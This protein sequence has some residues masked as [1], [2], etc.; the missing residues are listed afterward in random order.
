MNHSVFSALTPGTATCRVL[1]HS[2][3]CPATSL[4]AYSSG[5]ITGPEPVGCPFPPGDRQP[6]ARVSPPC[7]ACV[8][9]TRDT[10]M[11]GVLWRSSAECKQSPRLIASEGVSMTT[12]LPQLLGAQ[13]PAFLHRVQPLATSTSPTPARTMRQRSA[14]PGSSPPTA[15]RPVSRPCDPPGPARRGGRDRRSRRTGRPKGRPR[16]ARPETARSS[17]HQRVRDSP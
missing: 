5:W 8:L 10:A 16:S 6:M 13:M 1:G 11:P 9:R 17:S 2:S 14:A 12:D 15:C 3:E 7:P 4:P